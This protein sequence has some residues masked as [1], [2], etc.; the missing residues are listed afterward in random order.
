[1]S[2]VDKGEKVWWMIRVYSARVCTHRF[3]KT[4]PIHVRLDRRFALQTR[5]Q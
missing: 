1:M 4:F 5:L 2:G 3:Y